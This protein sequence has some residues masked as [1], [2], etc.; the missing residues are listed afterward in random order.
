MLLKMVEWK[1][2]KQKQEKEECLFILE[3][4]TGDKECKVII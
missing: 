3:V 2:I 1:K 4:E